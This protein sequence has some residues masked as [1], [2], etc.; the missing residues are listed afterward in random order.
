MVDLSLMMPLVLVLNKLQSSGM[1]QSTSTN[2]QILIKVIK[3]N[4][5]TCS[6]KDW[7]EIPELQKPKPRDGNCNCGACTPCWKVLY[8]RISD[9]QQ[10]SFPRGQWK[11][12]LFSCY[13]K[14]TFP[15]IQLGPQLSPW[16]FQ[17]QRSKGKASSGFSTLSALFYTI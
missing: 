10:H 11:W 8:G 6:K 12:F 13:L 2:T 14:V 15:R 9:R 7:E 5:G 17:V 4:P 16:K 3:S 1:P